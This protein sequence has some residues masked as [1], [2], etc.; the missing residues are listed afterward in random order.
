MYEK[1]RVIVRVEEEEME[2]DI[3]IEIRQ[4]YTQL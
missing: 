2:A 4:I 3:K 1:Q